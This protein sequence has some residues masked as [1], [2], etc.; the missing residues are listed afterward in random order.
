MP[1]SCAL[2]LLTAALGCSEGRK[3]APVSGR[4]T[5]DGQPVADVGVLF[6]PVVQPQASA[7]ASDAV[8]SIATTDAEGR[9]ELR[10]SD[11]NAPGAL[12]GPHTVRF[13]D[14]R[15]VSADDLDGGPSKAP[16]SR[17]AD[18]Y[19]EASETFEVPAEGT[20]TADFQLKSK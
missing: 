18:R 19:G 10:F 14:R 3:A 20:T 6:A 2:L 5:L 16:K 13:S 12:V 4:V 17:L 9:Y 1:R 7:E 15:A 11:T 8:T